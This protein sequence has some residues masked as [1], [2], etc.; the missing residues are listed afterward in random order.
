MDLNL[1][2]H[3]ALI[4][5]STLGIGFAIAQALRADGAD[6]I[7]NGRNPQRLDQ[8]VDKLKRSP[9]S[10]TVRGI[11]LDL[12]TAEGASKLLET[13]PAVDILVNN[14]GIFEPKPF[15]DIPDADWTRFFEIN[16]MSGVR[17][18]R[19][20]LP[21]MLRNNWGRIVFISSESGVQT[22][23]EMVHYGMTKSAQIAIARGIAEATAGTR[24]TVNSV[25]P[26]PTGTEGVQDFVSTL[27][28]SASQTP[29]EFEREFFKTVRP[30]S[31]LKRFQTPEEIAAVVALVCSPRGSGING[32]A[33]RVDG[34][35]VRSAF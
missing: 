25:L 15:V 2:N 28:T 9:G 6:V 13:L 7:I 8:A 1:A 27:A 11:A 3:S 22:P 12:G 23:A 17:L 35:V 18:S 16:V 34:G 10:G 32:S 14:L 29:A 31:L 4:T 19:A 21:A 24:V 33:L 5:G 20:Y 26:G 30:T